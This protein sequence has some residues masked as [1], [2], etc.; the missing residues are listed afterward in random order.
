M[1]KFIK[2][3]DMDGHTRYVN[4]DMVQEFIVEEK[5]VQVVFEEHISYVTPESFN[6]IP[7]S[8]PI[9]PNSVRQLND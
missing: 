8:H 6:P 9:F 7:D 1:D 4:P 3:T 2:L 5:C